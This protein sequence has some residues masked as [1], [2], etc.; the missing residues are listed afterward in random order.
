LSH[1]RQDK[2]DVILAR[3]KEPERTA[4]AAV[5]QPHFAALASA[6]RTVDGLKSVDERKVGQVFDLLSPDLRKEHEDAWRTE[7]NLLVETAV[8]ASWSEV[9]AVP[10]TAAGLRAGAEWLQAFSMNWK[11]YASEGPIKTTV[12]T[13][14][15]DRKERLLGALPEFRDAVSRA[16]PSG[17]AHVRSQFLVL[18]QDRRSPVALEYDLV[19]EGI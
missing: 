16:G 9:S 4:A 14:H 3:I 10:R 19:A 15:K 18:D 2:R 17:A 5:L 13:F 12:A 8:A 6:P 1:I 7:R 11:D